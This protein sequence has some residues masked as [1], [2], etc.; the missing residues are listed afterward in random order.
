MDLVLFLP[1]VVLLAVD[2]PTA[3]SSVGESALQK[4]KHCVEAAREAY[5]LLAQGDAGASTASA[6]ISHL[7]ALAEDAKYLKLNS[8][9]YLTEQETK[10]ESSMKTL[11][12]FQAQ[13]IQLE[14]EKTSASQNKDNALRDQS[15]KLAILQDNQNKVTQLQQ[16]MTNAENDLRYAKKK[17]KKKKKG[18][19]RIKHALGKLVGHVSGAEK[20]L[21]SAR[22]NLDRRRAELNAAQAAA[23]AAQ[24]AL[25]NS[26]EKLRQYQLKVQEIQQKIDAKQVEIKN[27]KVS[28]VLLQESVNF[29]QLFI[30]ATVS[31]EDRTSSL[32]QII[33]IIDQEKEY[34]ILQQD[35]T[36][37]KAKS[38]M[39]AWEFFTSI[40]QIE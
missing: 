37:T 39:E 9:N 38:F 14:K 5:Q 10:L 26:E 16:E 22:N 23:N 8:N 34:F 6:V 30:V 1:L 15:A 12:D 32:K 17:L 2:V 4:S 25:S 11:D 35:G 28:L 19:G 36:L 31:V 7:E 21:K 27:M 24:Q 40:H 20:R 29:W 18:W 33:D 3:R 13:K